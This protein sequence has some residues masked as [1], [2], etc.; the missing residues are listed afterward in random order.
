MATSMSKANAKNALD[1][2]KF[3]VASEVGVNLKQG[4]NG[5]NTAR[6][7]GTVGGYMVKRMFDQYYQKN[8][9]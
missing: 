3:E 8:G 5:D 4:Y 1:Q 7:N 6:Q 9:G 2:M